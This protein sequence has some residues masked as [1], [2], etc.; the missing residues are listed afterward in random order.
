MAIIKE[1]TDYQFVKIPA[2]ILRERT[3]SMKETGL[4]CKLY[5]LP[6]NWRFSLAGLA[7][8]LNDGIDS[9][10]GVL[11]SLIDKGYVERVT[12]RDEAGKFSGETLILKLPIEKVNSPPGS[13][14][15]TGS[16][17]PE[18]PYTENPHTV[19]PSS[20]NPQGEE[21][22]SGKATQYY[23]ND[24]RNKEYKNKGYYRGAPPK[25]KSGNAVAGKKNT[26]NNFPQ[27]EYDKSQVE[28]L[29]NAQRQENIWNS[30]TEKTM[31]SWK[32]IEKDLL[33]PKRPLNK[34][35]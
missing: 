28:K 16:P 6:E 3:L 27:R 15:K 9:I 23:N 13:K 7:K 10:R 19:N 24:N 21:P 1:S 25:G 31:E 35:S 30:G 29:E 26:F 5:S 32:Q 11:N 14:M 22:D 34:V 18:N 17:E 20:D 12:V 8:I 4:L 33:D 2:E